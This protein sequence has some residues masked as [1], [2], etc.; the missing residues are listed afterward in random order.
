MN[1]EGGGVFQGSF[2]TALFA[3]DLD[4]KAQLRR[5]PYPDFG[6]RTLHK[7]FQVTSISFL[8]KIL[9]VGLQNEIN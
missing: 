5:T 8:L 7:S 4:M 6:L 3:K 2:A 9:A 1:G